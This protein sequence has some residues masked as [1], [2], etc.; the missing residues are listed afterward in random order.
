MIPNNLLKFFKRTPPDAIKNI[1]QDLESIGIGS[2]ASYYPRD[3]MVTVHLPY[4]VYKVENYL[5]GYSLT[6]KDIPI[7]EI[8]SSTKDVADRLL[9]IHRQSYKPANVDNDKV[10]FFYPKYVKDII[11]QEK[12]KI[13]LPSDNEIVEIGFD[14]AAMPITKIKAKPIDIVM[15]HFPRRKIRGGYSMAFELNVYASKVAKHTRLAVANAM[16]VNPKFFCTINKRMGENDPITDTCKGHFGNRFNWITFD[17]SLPENVI[18]LYMDNVTQPCSRAF[19]ITEDGYAVNPIIEH[20]G[21]IL[22]VGDVSDHFD[23]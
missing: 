22:E 8:Y 18:V 11:S 7:H 20:M 6:G 1:I 13:E 14:A 4:A 23:K 15:D 21:F 12:M 19:A 17:E 16:I 3:E 10:W 9:E 5:N 2:I